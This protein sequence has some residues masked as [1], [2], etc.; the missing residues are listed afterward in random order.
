A[1]RASARVRLDPA[2]VATSLE[3]LSLDE[4]AALG[5]ELAVGPVQLAVQ[6]RGLAADR[7]AL[8]PGRPAA[9]AQAG[10][11]VPLRRLRSARP[12][13]RPAALLPP[14]VPGRERA[15]LPALVPGL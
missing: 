15:R 2:P 4:R 14:R 11:V 13:L 8:A 10:R 9:F 12:P 3:R 1:A 6:E 7:S 5:I